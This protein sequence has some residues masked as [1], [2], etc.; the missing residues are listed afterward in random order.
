MDTLELEKLLG[1]GGGEF[2]SIWN[3]RLTCV[4]SLIGVIMHKLFF[5]G[6]QCIINVF[7]A[8]VLMI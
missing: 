7:P 3:T 6:R 5:D 8:N 4:S 1:L 2:R